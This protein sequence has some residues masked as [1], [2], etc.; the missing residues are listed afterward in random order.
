ML[1]L[2]EAGSLLLGGGAEHARGLEGKEETADGGTDPEG[3][4]DDTEDLVAEE[5]AAAAEEGT[6]DLLVSLGLRA[7]VGANESLV[8]EEA[9]GDDAPGAAGT[10][11]GESLERI[12]DPELEEELGGPPED[13]GADETGEDAIG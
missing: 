12:V 10:V 7:H 6:V 11:D 5:L 13:D 1:G 3:D 8:G 9:D 2:V 4:D